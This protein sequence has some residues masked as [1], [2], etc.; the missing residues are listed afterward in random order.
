MSDIDR[1]NSGDAEPPAEPGNEA[2]PS[3]ALVPL[4]PAFAGTTGT[5]HRPSLFLAQLIAAKD[6]HPQARERRRAEPEEAMH[7]YA[8]TLS[9]NL[10]FN[11]YLISR[12]L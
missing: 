9:P 6:Q 5:A 2:E 12:A 1:I 10:S 7:A 3:R 8:A 11:G 4:A